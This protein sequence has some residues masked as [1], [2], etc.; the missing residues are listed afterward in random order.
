MPSDSTPVSL[1]PVDLILDD[2]SIW[3]LVTVVTVTPSFV[4]KV[5]IG[6]PIIG[7]ERLIRREFLVQSGD[8]V[9]SQPNSRSADLVP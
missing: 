6:A 9:P 2:V 7:I 1:T 4:V 5:V 3:A 8:H